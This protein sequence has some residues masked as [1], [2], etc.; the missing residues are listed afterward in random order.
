MIRTV[1]EHILWITNF[2]TID[3]MI[4]ELGEFVK[5]YNAN[6]LCQRHGELQISSPAERRGLNRSTEI[7][8]K[9]AT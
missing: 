6:W 3:D 2:N 1:K 8:I 7:G 5:K 4:R 9:E